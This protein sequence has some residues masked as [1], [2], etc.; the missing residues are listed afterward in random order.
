MKKMPD[1]P[2][3]CYYCGRIAPCDELSFRDIEYRKKICPECRTELMDILSKSA[4][5]R[6]LGKPLGEVFFTQK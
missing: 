6:T 4:I 5:K 1:T 3:H 2:M